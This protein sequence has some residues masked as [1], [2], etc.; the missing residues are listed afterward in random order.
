MHMELCLVFSDKGCRTVF[1]KFYFVEL[2]NFFTIQR[3][4]YSMC[5]W[6]LYFSIHDI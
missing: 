1:Y 4:L 6:L 2:Y 5:A 3:F